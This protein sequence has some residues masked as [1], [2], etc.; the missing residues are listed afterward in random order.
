MLWLTS[1]IAGRWLPILWAVVSLACLATAYG[2]GRSHANSRW[3]ARWAAA[4]TAARVASAEQEGRWKGRADAAGRE[5][6]EALALVAAR[7]AVLV[8]YAR[9]MQDLAARPRRL[10]AAATPADFARELAAEQ[11]RTA[12]MGSLLASCLREGAGAAGS[13]AYHWTVADEARDAWPR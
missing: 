9:R 5:R 10:P 12:G 1:W 3:E 7:D 13:S 8:D 4:E 2:Y 6:D 11:Q